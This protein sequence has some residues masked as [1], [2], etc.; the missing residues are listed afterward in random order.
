MA[1]IKLVHA[2]YA[3]GAYKFKCPGCTFTH[4]VFTQR[5]PGRHCWSFNGNVD[6]PTFSPSL[7]VTMPGGIGED[8]KPF[9]CH[10]FVKDGHI[11]FLGD[12]THDKAGQTVPLFDI[13]EVQE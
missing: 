3:E 5:L 11:E 10:S 6:R 8:Q 4:I 2:D 1:R 9:V 7:L 13:E 12:C